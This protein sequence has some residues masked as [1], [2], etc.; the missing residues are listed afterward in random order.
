M[1]GDHQALSRPEAK[2][3]GRGSIRLWRRLVGARYLGAQDGVP[4][5]AGPPGHV[6][7]E[8]DIPVR[9]CRQ[10]EP[11]PEPGQPGNGIGPGVEPVPGSVQVLDLLLAERGDGELSEHGAQAL[12]MQVIELCPRAA[13]APHLLE[14]RLISAAP[15]FGEA[16]PVRGY[17]PAPGELLPLANDA[18]PPV[19]H[20][21]EDVEGE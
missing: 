12:A 8:R 17:A 4:W 11:S 1:S 3:L 16:P 7:H 15:G 19:D 14:G 21:A 5:Q 13:P 6:D 20:G 18:A 9:E 10:G 2:H